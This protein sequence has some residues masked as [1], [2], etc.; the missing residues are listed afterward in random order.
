MVVLYWLNARAYMIDPTVADLTPWQAV[1]FSAGLL[2]MGWIVYDLLCRFVRNEKVL[3][4]LIFLGIVGTARATAQ[5]YAP[6]AAWLQTGAMIGSIMVGSVF[7]NI[8]PAHWELIRAKEAGRDPDPA[9]GIE[10]KRRSVHNNYFTLPVLVTMLAGHFT[11]VTSR[12]DAWMILVFLMLFGAWSRLFFNLRHQGKTH[13]WMI[14]V[15]AVAVIALAIAI[16]PE[17]DSAP[18]PTPTTNVGALTG[19]DVFAANCAACHTL[20]AANSTGSVGPNLDNVHPE[21]DL[22]FERV[23][24]GKGGMPSFR[25]KLSQ[26]EINAVA[27]Y[28]S[29]SAAK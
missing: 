8:I 13:W 29:T 12:D 14:G 28:V 27:D 22:V 5:L 10:A 3:W 9:P 23:S 11:F 6:R 19:P 21:K 25:G 7:F 20:S 4:V 17:D 24:N 2:A 1:G 15:G 16:K 18:T 26:D